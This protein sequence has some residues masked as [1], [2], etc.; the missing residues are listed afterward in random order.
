MHWL[1]LQVNISFTID[2]KTKLKMVLGLR[3][4]N[5][6]PSC[7]NKDVEGYCPCYVLDWRL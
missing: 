5:T 1:F 6:V 2:E 7:K 3:N 4:I